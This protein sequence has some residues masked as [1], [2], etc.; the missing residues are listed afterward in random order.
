VT[1]T[2]HFF[3]G[4]DALGAFR[5]RQ[6]LA[7]LQAL[8]PRIIGLAA[9]FVHVVHA[10]APLAPSVLQQLAALLEYGEPYAGPDSG[11]LVV[12][13]PRLG[14]VSP[15]ASKATDIAHNCGLAVHRIERIAQGLRMRPSFKTGKSTS[16][17]K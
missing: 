6:L 9:R 7:A 14:T 12:V 3:P 15:W 2:T 16:P 1:P 10:D 8:H 13:T 4:S 11:E 17:M 5:A